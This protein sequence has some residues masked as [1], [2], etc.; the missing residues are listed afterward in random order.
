MSYIYLI[1][2]G[3]PEMP[4]D[5]S[6]CIGSGS[7]WPLSSEGRTQAEA[8]IPWLEK[9]DVDRIFCSTLLRSRETADLISD[10]RWP[11][12]PRQDLNEISVG[13]WEGLSFDEIRARYPQLYA[14]RSQ[15]WSIVPPGGENLLHAA[16][17]MEKAIK[18]MAAEGSS[19]IPAVTHDGAVRA[20]LWKLLGLDTKKDAMV[21]QPYGSI[22]VLKYENALLS[23]EAIGK[24]PNNI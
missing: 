3:R 10:D 18:E 12:S 8:L 11:L 24:L 9:L 16:A 4:D 6:Y 14:A 5:R 15:D 13:E 17:R 7:N 19:H 23:V 20:L 22:T 21:R 1:R 2:H